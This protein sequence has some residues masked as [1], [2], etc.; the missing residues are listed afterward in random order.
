MSPVPAPPPLAAAAGVAPG[1]GPGDPD[2]SSSGGSGTMGG[3]SGRVAKVAAAPPP[4]TVPL[5]G[6]AAAAAAATAPAAAA[7]AAATASTAGSS[8]WPAGDDD[9]RRPGRVTDVGIM[10]LEVYVPALA[11][12]AA[13]LEVA[14][15]VSPGKYTEGLGQSHMAFVSD[16]EDVT[17]LALTA[18]SRLLASTGLAPDDVGYLA[19]ATE[20][21]VDRSKSI[22]SSL[23][24]LFPSATAVEGVDVTHAC[25]GSTAALFAAAAWA[26]SS[27]WDGRAALVVAADIAL[28]GRG[29]ARATGG[30]GAVAMLVGRGCGGGGGGGGGGG[31]GSGGGG[32]G[33]RVALAFEVG[34]RSTHMECT[35]DFCKP[36]V[37]T[38]V[39]VV[40][41]AETVAVFY[42]CLS[43][44]YDRWRVVAAAAAAASAAATADTGAAAGIAVSGAPAT[45]REGAPTTRRAPIANGIT[46]PSGG[47]DGNISD[48]GNAGNVGAV[49]PLPPA[50]DASHPT[51]P[52][53]YTLRLRAGLPVQWALF[54]APFHKMVRRALA[55][56]VWA[57]LGAVG[58]AAAAAAAYPPDLASWWPAASASAAEAATAEPW[59]FPPRP[60]SAEAGRRTPPTPPACLLSTPPPFP[61]S[62]ARP[63]DTGGFP[64][65][66]AERA[67]VAATTPLFRRLTAPSTDLSVATGNA[68]TA[69][70]YLS[71]AS[72]VR[73]TGPAGPAVGDR[74]LLFAFGSGAASSLFSLRVMAPLSGLA[75]GGSGATA[76]G[77]GST[78]APPPRPSPLA[79]RRVVGVAAYEA[80]CAAR[81]AS[82]G[83][84][85][86]VPT[87][88]VADVAPGAWYLVRVEADGRRVYRRKGEEG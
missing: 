79:G 3:G 60:V 43:I 25:Y 9:Y 36:L 46:H 27:A 50:G 49:C 75:T 78:P 14:D 62:R 26:E 38:E 5:T 88:A 15:G 72:L 84:A 82:F 56:L 55:R 53:A 57:D 65:K 16:R 35:W 22:K 61:D 40:D 19:V 37:A 77:G 73:Q 28:Y 4:R 68:Y 18:T 70:L 58:S 1:G 31:S 32:G 54:H 86:W 17:S 20:S 74:L 85:G 10:A 67:F 12:A 42:R 83:R 39:P 24:A 80:A 23:M 33:P 48:N 51:P 71:L 13:D 44:C 29:P 59:R 8:L 76:V 6:R 34:L 41:G 11:V 2:G 30:A 69:S 45:G 63:V 7:A 47:C 52:D 66:A 87:G 81:A 64:S 21:R